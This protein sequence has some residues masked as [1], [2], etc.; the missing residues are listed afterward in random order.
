MKAFLRAIAAIVMTAA[1]CIAPTSCKPKAVSK[2]ALTTTVGGRKVG[3]IIDG[4]AFIQTQGQSAVISTSANKIAVEPERVVLD[5]TELAKLAAA[6][7][8]VEVTVSGGTLTVTA[9]GAMIST[10]QLGK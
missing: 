3:A 9:D 10:K 5:G 8:N 2:S 7:T 4:P 1:L 6:A